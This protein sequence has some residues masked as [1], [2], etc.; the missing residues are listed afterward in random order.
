MKS[1]SLGIIDPRVV[2]IRPARPKDPSPVLIQCSVT[3]PALS[4]RL[5]LATNVVWVLLTG[6]SL[7]Y[8]VI[9]LVLI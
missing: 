8:N 5:T 6:T 7:I 1:N 4:E 2:S 3:A 9:Y